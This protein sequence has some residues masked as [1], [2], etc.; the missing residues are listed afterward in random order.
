MRRG[1]P[2]A[3]AGCYDWR[4]TAEE[5]ELAWLRM[6]NQS[7]F[8]PE[9]VA[10]D[11]IKQLRRTRN[12]AAVEAGLYGFTKAKCPRCGERGH[13][14]V[15]PMGRLNHPGC[16]AWRMHPAEFAVH[17]LTEKLAG[18]PPEVAQPPQPPPPPKYTGPV[19]GGCGEPFPEDR[20]FCPRCGRRRMT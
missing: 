17:M 14:R 3:H 6:C 5:L 12:K 13:F 8:I 7:E 19:C 2:A 1:V 11:F 15:G 10:K 16:A 4:V 9:R 18:P 20:Q